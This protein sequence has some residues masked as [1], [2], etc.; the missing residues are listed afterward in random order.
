MKIKATKTFVNF[1]NKVAKDRNLQ[2]SAE[3]AE[4]SSNSYGFLVGDIWSADMDYNFKT[5]KYRVIRIVYP[6]E[7]YCNPVYV[8]TD[9]LTR[10]FRRYGV[11]DIESLKDMICDLYAV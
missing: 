7:Y 3:L 11:K 6:Y 2:F 5:D 10:N 8:S 1:I 9:N 4:I